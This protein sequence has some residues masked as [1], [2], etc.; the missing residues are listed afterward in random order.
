MSQLINGGKR[1]TMRKRNNGLKA[2]VTFVKKV[3]KEE[4]KRH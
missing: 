4:N 1:N 2:W 3:Q